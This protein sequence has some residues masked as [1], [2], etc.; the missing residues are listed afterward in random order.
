MIVL[1]GAKRKRMEDGVRAPSLKMINEVKLISSGRF[2]G[3]GY[4][5]ETSKSVRDLINVYE[6]P[7]ER[8]T[9]SSSSWMRDLKRERLVEFTGNKGMEYL[10]PVKRIRTTLDKGAA[11]G[12]HRH[13]RLPPRTT[14]T[15]RAVWPCPPAPGQGPGGETSSPPT[16][17]SARGA[18]C[19]PPPPPQT[20]W[21]GAC[22]PW[23]C[24]P[25]PGQGPGGAT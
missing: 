16:S 1:G 21:R 23:P 15:G 14:G 4:Y 12:A 10:S 25:A 20:A 22:P 3:T 24:T 17:P 6:H 13:A 7:Q 8:G 9:S 18:P 5:N 2:K 19:R 11:A